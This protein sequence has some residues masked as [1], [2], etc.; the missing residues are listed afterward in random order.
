MLKPFAL[1]LLTLPFPA[2]AQDSPIDGALIEICLRDAPRGRADADCIGIAARAC[3]AWTGETTVQINT[4][5]EAER[6]EWD[7]ALNREYKE[8][9]DHFK[10]RPGIAD[11]LK[12]AQK[13]WIGLRDAD[14][15]AEGLRY[16]GG[17]MQTTSTLYCQLEH[18]A[19]RALEL[20][21]M[22]DP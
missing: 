7:E 18:T 14:C 16:E 22:R 5:I 15:E 21:N 1:L 11:K 6:K 12:V 10:D 2:L 4:C 8:T 19:R 17:T 3:Q 13:S 20:R 9:R